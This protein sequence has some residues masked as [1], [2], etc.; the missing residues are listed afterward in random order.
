MRTHAGERAKGVIAADREDMVA[1]DLDGSNRMVHTS[2][3]C[4]GYEEIRNQDFYLEISPRRV[5]AT[6]AKPTSPEVKATGG[7]NG[8]KGDLSDC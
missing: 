4:E 8:L 6:R 2:D 1:R 3:I 5:G 7:G